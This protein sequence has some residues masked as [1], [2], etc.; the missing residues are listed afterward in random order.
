MSSPAPDAL[1]TVFHVTHWKSGSQWVSSVLKFAVGER[2][3]HPLAGQGGPLGGPLRKGKIYSPVYASR[4]QFLAHVPDDA[5][6]RAFVVIRDPRD[7]LVSWYFSLMYS[8]ASAEPTVQESRDEL[9]SMKKA[10]ALALMIGKHMQEV[11][12]I[13]R[14]WVTAGAR[15][16]RY[17]DLVADEQET[18]RQIFEFCQVPTPALRR[19]WIV[20]RHSFKV[21]T[22]S[23]LGRENAKS[24]LRKGV[25][26]DWKNHFCDET[27]RLF[28][29]QF[30]QTLALTGYEKD[31]TW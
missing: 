3:I 4:E 7:T 9:R 13:Q 24:H 22:W 20:F 5:A 18:F 10:D 27:K 19:R 31:D 16:F 8:H 21:L 14:E 30:G 25:P 2:L 1:P 6:N 23:R 26:G 28:K 29:A 17:E 15:I 11:A 12:R